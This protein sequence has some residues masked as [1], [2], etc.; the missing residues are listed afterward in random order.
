M[1]ILLNSELPSRLLYAS[2]ELNDYDFILYHLFV[3]NSEYRD[4]FSHVMRERERMTI[5]DNSAYEFHRDGG[6]FNQFEFQK[7][8]EEFSPTYFIVPD[9]LMDAKLTLSNFKAWKSIFP[10]R[11]RMVVPQGK[12]FKE[13]LS[14]YEEMLAD[15]N[16]EYIGIPFHNDFFW[17][18]GET[19]YRTPVDQYHN[20]LTWTS[21]MAYAQGRCWLMNYLYQNQLVD[22][23][24]KY[25]LLGSHNPLEL[26]WLNQCHKN[27]DCFNWITSMDT[28]YPVTKGIMKKDLEDGEKEKISIDD[29]FGMS[30]DKDQRDQITKNIQKFHG[31]KN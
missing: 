28:S 17:D 29:F 15:G 16:F 9:V 8:L 13:W 23:N 14:C 31:Y 11:K 20:P 25:H 26:K 18:I 10:E 1:N 12:S 21:D 3:K 24:K 30:L 6:K 19:L 4:Y 5:L 2:E 27:R 22:E 7:I